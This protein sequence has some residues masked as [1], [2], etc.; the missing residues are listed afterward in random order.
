[1]RTQLKNYAR[2]GY[3]GLCIVTCEEIRAEGEI[4]RAADEMGSA[5]LSWSFGHGIENV[6]EEKHVEGTDDH[7]KMLSWLIASM[8]GE[9]LTDSVVIIK[10]IHLFIDKERPNPMLV[11]SLKDVITAGRTCNVIILLLGCRSVI[12]PELEKEL[13]VLEFDLPTRDQLKS[14]LEEVAESGNVKLNGETDLL[15]D[16]ASG[17]T[18]T[19]AADAFGL[20]LIESKDNGHGGIDPKIVAREKAGLVKK[21]GLLEIVKDNVSLDDIGGLENLKQSLYD[22]RNRFT[23]EARDYGLPTPRP[24]LATGMAGTGKSLTAQAT[25]SIFGIPL[26]RLEAGRLFGSLVGQTEQ[27]WRTAF[28][29]VKAIAP[30]VCWIDEVDG[31]TS[32]AESSG[33]TDGGTTSRVIKTIL[34]D[35]QYNSDGVFF[36]FTAND[37]DNLPDPLIDRCDVWSV[38]LPTIDER[39]E[40]WKIHIAKRDR[41]PDQFKIREF[42]AHS[43]GFSGRQ[44]EQVW[45]KAMTIAFNDG[46]R[47]PVDKDV[48]D[49]L[50]R[51]VP[52]SQ[53]MADQIE[54]RRA[55]LKD[56]AMPASREAKSKDVTSR[57]RKVKVA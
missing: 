55:R 4:K 57:K 6:T 30:C 40:I 48:L 43:D 15:L 37:I 41:K 12:P 25:G 36:M 38:D 29:T 3:G 46:A 31:L 2:A 53:T 18:S 1:M 33:K 28:S 8:T 24:I 44:I 50:K 54:Q 16:A 47:E 10:D 23:K 52:T 5:T 32:G 17:L 21:S 9:Q 22:S 13:T 51:T 27:N 7:M 11:R 45:I 14:V 20:A 19:E 39:E 42:A 34:Q 56:K 35:L 26:L 49:V